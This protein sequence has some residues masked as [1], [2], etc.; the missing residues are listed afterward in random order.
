[1][2]LLRP[3]QAINLTRCHDTVCPVKEHCLRSS[4]SGLPV[5]ELTVWF[6][7]SP[8]LLE[9]CAVFEPDGV[10]GVVRFDERLTAAR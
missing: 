1:M 5:N 8:R 6:Q 4:A 3:M 7:G 10:G 9:G 2:A